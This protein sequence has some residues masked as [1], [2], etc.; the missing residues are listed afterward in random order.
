MI[1]EN[2]LR[3]LE[4][5]YGRISQLE[6]KIDQLLGNSRYLGRG[7]YKDGA[8]DIYQGLSTALLRSLFQTGKPPSPNYGTTL[9]PLA[10]MM[11]P[12]MS[13][14]LFSKQNQE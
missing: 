3:R 5:N 8:I 13:S 10:L 1:Q 11:T 2:R 14:P 7:S 6:A 12:L 4:G 9:V